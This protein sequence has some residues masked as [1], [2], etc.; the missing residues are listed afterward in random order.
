MAGVRLAV[1][2]P[3]GPAVGPDHVAGV[4][5]SPA[6]RAAELQPAGPGVERGR[7]GL[8]AH[9][10]RQRRDIQPPVRSQQGQ[11]R[12]LL[13]AQ[14]AGGQDGLD[15]AD[16]GHGGVRTGRSED[17]GRQK[18]GFSLRSRNLGRRRAD[19]AVV[20]PFPGPIRLEL[21]DRE[22]VAGTGAADFDPAGGEAEIPR[23]GDARPVR[24]PHQRGRGRITGGVRVED[25]VRQAGR[26]A[27]DHDRGLRRPL[28]ERGVDAQHQAVGGEGAFGLDD[29]RG[30]G[31]LGP[32]GAGQGE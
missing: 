19:A 22:I 16:L 11:V 8:G 15:G 17:G 3:Q 5:R 2:G 18:R 30:F 4:R 23:L 31:R 29:M 14:G 6:E 21:P 20:D 12:L 32:D 26:A 10:R 27:D 9:G 25:L 24:P 7:E 1:A 28:Q 13:V